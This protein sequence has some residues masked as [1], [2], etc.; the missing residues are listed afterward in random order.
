MSPSPLASAPLHFPGV[1][2]PTLGDRGL[3]PN[4]DAKAYL[5]HAAISPASLCVT[6]AVAHLIEMV[7]RLGVGSFPIYQEQR[8]RLRI[9]AAQLFGVQPSSIALTAGCT[10]GIT[11]VALALPWAQGDVLLT[12][13]GEFPA[14]VTPWQ[15]AARAKQAHVS[16]L[17]LPAPTSPTFTQELLTELKLAFERP[18]EGR[19]VRY[20]AVSAV[21]FQTGLKMPIAEMVAL[22]KEYSV[23]VLVDGIQ[24]AGVTEQDL[25]ALEVDAFFVGAHKWLL[26]LEGAGLSYLSP[27]L[28]RELTPVTAG[29]LSHPSGDQFLFAGAGHLRYDRDLLDTASVFEG[30]TAAGVAFVALESGLEIC[31]RLSPQ[32][33]LNHVQDYHDAVE[34][35]LIGRGFRS[36][37][38]FDPNLRSTLLSFEFP[39]GIT[40]GPFARALREEGIFVSI[41]DGLLRLSPHFSNHHDE[42][43]LVIS[44]VDRALRLF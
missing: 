36:L 9:S 21:Q 37:R 6:S 23:R 40:P 31:R 2:E 22:A 5:A 11:D 12:F 28:L 3:F 34:A 29:W 38:A 17:K 14:N 20:L 24:G 39:R 10:R 4:L 15:L 44:A 25:G 27:D 32:A 35:E 7:S 42:I 1:P 26:G 16:L 19:C 13:E 18:P 41:P 30:S 33:I 43:P 8:E